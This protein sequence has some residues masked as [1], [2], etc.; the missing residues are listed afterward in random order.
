MRIAAIDYSRY[1]KGYAADYVKPNLR[2][3]KALK[4]SFSG[5]VYLKEEEVTILLTK[6]YLEKHTSI[7]IEYNIKGSKIKLGARVLNKPTE[8]H[9]TTLSGLPKLINKFWPNRAVEFIE[10][11]NKEASKWLL[12]LVDIL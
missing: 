3:I 6:E 4:D 9:E 7:K 5:P 2:I 10:V 8:Y 11:S 1:P 12:N